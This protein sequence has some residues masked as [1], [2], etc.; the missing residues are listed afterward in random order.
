MVSA[1]TV[2]RAATPIP[3]GLGESGIS[4]EPA[5]GVASSPWLVYEVDA[6]AT[7]SDAA[8][9]ANDSETARS[10]DIYAADARTLPSGAFEADLQQVRPRQ[11]GAWTRL[12]VPHLDLP[13][14]TRRRVPL[15]VQ[16]PISTE[17]GE[18][19]GSILVQFETA[20]DQQVR[21]VHRV[22]LREYLTVKG[23]LA[24]S[25]RV[26]S[27]SSGH[28][29][30]RGW[31]GDPVELRTT[32]ANTG[33]VHLKVSGSARTGGEAF[34]LTD[35]GGEIVVLRNSQSTLLAHL[36]SR[37]WIG[38]QRLGID[39]AYSNRSS[40]H[41]MATTDVWF[42][43]WKALLLVLALVILMAYAGWRS[44]AW[45]RRSRTL[46]VNLRG[47]TMRMAVVDP[48]GQPAGLPSPPPGSRL[49]VV[50]LEVANDGSKPLRFS[51]AR[52][53]L[54]DGQNRSFSPD[55]AVSKT[56]VEKLDRPVPPGRR[57][58]L[59]LAFLLPVGS[60]PRAATYR[61]DAG[62][63]IVE[64]VPWEP[65]GFSSPEGSPP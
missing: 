40:G 35:G 63:L 49:V 5:A 64:T 20:D 11:L 24:E 57:E 30:E 54:L 12:A 17:A 46:A 14:H 1:P 50:A 4:V 58:V 19:E 10:L 27:V 59:M 25:G 37:P 16:V 33:R 32:F 56:L 62:R 44:R 60:E 13:P 36:P 43:P 45:L 47:A 18:Y 6:G 42:I 52:F 21:I 34:P 3:R 65:E 8:I 28:W 61:S 23:S 48:G 15:V 22:G 2:A 55:P 9:V 38:M 31:P 51:P 53:E 39:V 26:E 7:I 41:A 29:W